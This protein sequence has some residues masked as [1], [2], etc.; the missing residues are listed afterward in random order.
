MW[1]VASA[2]ACIQYLIMDAYV[3]D[4]VKKWLEGLLDVQ[5]Q[6]IQQVLVQALLE[7]RP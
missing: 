6:R 3:F 4:M 7:Q 5:Q 2:T 1:F